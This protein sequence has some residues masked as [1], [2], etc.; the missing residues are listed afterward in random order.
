MNTVLLVFQKN[1]E[2]GKVKT[3]LA[4]SIG[5]FEALNIYKKLVTHT[6]T[7]IDS[8]KAEKQIWYSNF[9]Q[10]NDIWHTST[11]K[12]YKQ[13]GSSLGSRMQ[14]AF[15]AAFLRPTITKVI[16]VGTDCAEI[17]TQMVE[18]AFSTLDKNDFVLGPAKDGGYYLLGMQA[19]YPSVFVDIPWSTDQAFSYT[20]KTI[21]KLNKNVCFLPTLHDVDTLEDWQRARKYLEP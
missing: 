16:I 20:V 12:K 14:Y 3:R 17:N 19:F 2:L 15:E 8:V 18:T 6:K 7:I 5:D 21:K 13:Q 9:I 4:S 10:E 11:Y 1:I